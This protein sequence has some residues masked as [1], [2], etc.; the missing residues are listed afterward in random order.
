MD[1]TACDNKRRKAEAET[2]HACD[3]V[4]FR[5]G[6]TRGGREE[7]DLIYGFSAGYRTVHTHIL[8]SW[9]GCASTR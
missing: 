9:W 3:V 2:A 6:M 5:I 1:V 4:R 8:A 7:E